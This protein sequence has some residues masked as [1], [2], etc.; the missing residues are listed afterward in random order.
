MIKVKEDLTDKTFEKLKV[1]EQVEDYISSKGQ[2]RSKWKCQCECGNVIEVVGTYLKSGN[3][4]SCGCMRKESIHNKLKKYNRY[5]FVNNYV[6]MYTSKGEPFYVDLEDFNK[7]KDICWYINKQGYV[8]GHLYIN[9]KYKLVL[10][11][12]F[13]FDFPNNFIIDHIH[14]KQT[15]SDNRR[16]NLRKCTISQNNMNKNEMCNNTSGRIGVTWDKNN[17][18]WMA[19]IYVNG[20][21][22]YLGRYLNKEDA[23]TARKEAED[24]Y[25]GEFSYDNSQ[26]K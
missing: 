10:L 4:K 1:L 21:Y 5:E 24:K 13:I 15:R 3:T 25:F 26:I 22:I 16:S 7:V 19:Q 23:I 8:A 12:Q 2:H 11:H 14:G 17:K 6:I 18:K 9:G 20:K